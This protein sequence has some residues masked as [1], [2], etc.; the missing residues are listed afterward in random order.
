MT[1]QNIAKL[2][3]ESLLIVFSVLLALFLNEYLN[4]RKAQKV[5]ENALARVVSELEANQA[6]VKEWAPYHNEVLG[7]I[8]KA[9]RNDS[10]K[11]TL[12]TPQGVE[13]WNLM[14]NGVV[15]QL[16]DDAAWQALKSSSAF[17]DLSFDTVLS[18]SKV[19]KLEKVGV[20]STIKSIL[21]IINAR[22][23]LHEENLQDTLVLLG[24]G[25]NELVAQEL[26]LLDQYEKTLNEL[27]AN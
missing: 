16:I 13:F 10:I 6:T 8:K 27:D 22:E 7:N 5:K 17:S 14:P 3:I 2:V 26:F 24:K 20:E 1:K 23:S 12:K 11:N 21:E 4:T 19:Y 18:L 15:Q 9:L 25:F